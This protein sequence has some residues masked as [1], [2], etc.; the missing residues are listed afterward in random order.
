MSKVEAVFVGVMGVH[1]GLCCRGHPRDELYF[2]PIDGLSD[3]SKTGSRSGL[4]P[5][6]NPF[7][8][9]TDSLFS[10]WPFA[11]RTTTISPMFPSLPP[12]SPLVQEQLCDE[13]RPS[14]SQS[15]ASHPSPSLIP[16][17]PTQFRLDPTLQRRTST[18]DRRHGRSFPESFPFGPQTS[19]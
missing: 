16:K 7:Y 15:A 6:D 5:P 10:S 11:S 12:S 17:I 3:S 4:P 9:S 14:Q 2:I 8:L 13:Q 18:T 1:V 19:F